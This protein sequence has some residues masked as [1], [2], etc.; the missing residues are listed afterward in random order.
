MSKDNATQY[1]LVVIG[2]GSGGVRAARWSAALGAKVAI[3]EE[4]RYGGTCVLRGCIPKKMMVYAGHFVDDI[5]TAAN[6]GLDIEVKGH[7]WNGFRKNREKELS[8]LSGLYENMLTKNGVEVFEGR[9]KIVGPHTVQV[10]TRKLSAKNII[11]A[12]G[13]KPWH[14]SL[15]HI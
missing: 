11:I 12:V 14:L 1:D 6:F 10:G 7:D 4:D 3:V 5:H 8:R 2:G 9:G 13:G 15:I